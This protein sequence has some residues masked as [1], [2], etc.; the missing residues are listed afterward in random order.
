[1]EGVLASEIGPGG[2]GAIPTTRENGLGVHLWRLDDTDELKQVLQEDAEK[3]S[4][5]GS[6]AEEKPAQN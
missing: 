4:D 5:S 3:K 2:T 6:T 1:M